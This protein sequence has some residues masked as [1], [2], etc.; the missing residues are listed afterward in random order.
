MTDPKTVYQAWADVMATIR[1]VGKGGINR[2]QGFTFRGIEQVQNAVGPA[3]REHGVAVV[4]T[5]EAIDVERYQTDR[6]TGMMGVIV[7]M[8]F[9]VFGPAGDHFTGRAYGQA[10]DAGDKA[11]TKAQSVALR[12]FLTQALMIPTND[13]DPDE[14]AHERSAVA[15]PPVDP[16][17]QAAR[18][19]L[20][21]ATEGHGSTRQEREAK[22]DKVLQEIGTTRG[23][24][25]AQ[26]LRE[27]ITRLDTKPDGVGN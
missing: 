10:S 11:V 20:W 9:T 7:T 8:S 6:G 12:T 5:V 25:S 13:P 19:E 15:S 14:E 4:P 3:L 22:M 17:L 21:R 24:A 2:Q 27:A 16:A 23:G 26:Q 18:G 1:S